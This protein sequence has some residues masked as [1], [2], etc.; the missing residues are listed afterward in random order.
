VTEV[1]ITGIG[2]VSC[3]GYG[4]AALWKAM[5]AAPVQLPQHPRDPLAH[6]DLPLIYLVPDE[7]GHRPPDD[8]RAAG[9]AVAAAEEALLDAGL[10][11]AGEQE[12]TR[13]GT[14]IGSCMGEAG[15]HERGRGPGGRNPAF[16]IAARVGDRIGWFGA[17]TSI[18]NAC[19]ASLF[20]VST[21]VDM[22]RCGEADVVL[23]GGADAYSRVALGCFNRMGAVDPV[24]CRPFDRHR[25]GTVFGEGAGMVVLESGEH[26]AA[27]GAHG[28]A[29]VAGAGWSCDAY[30][31]TAP[32]PG[33]EQIVRAMREALADA[34]VAAQA[35]GR[36]GVGVGAVIP[37]GTGTSLNDVVES[38]AL[39]GVLGAGGRD[40]PLYSLKALLGHTGGAAAGL[41]IAAAAMILRHGSVPA[42]V[43]LEEQDPLCEVWLPQSGPT[44]L[45]ES[46]L[47]VNAY[48]FGGNNASVVL[49]EAA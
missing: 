17:N 4:A 34:G 19:A 22:I 36:A 9:F 25:A 2:A 3:H 46:S 12:R 27:R 15:L 14:V 49:R 10:A 18:A 1:L 38:Q 8:D 29:R 30:H 44:L 11:G 7:P 20:A 48:A 47:L 39:A 37:H 23:A 35:G 5:T 31:V 28:Y 13:F 33:G 32:D 24:R 21:G 40:V 6:M 41:S 43:Q 16:R 45:R 26:A 42:N